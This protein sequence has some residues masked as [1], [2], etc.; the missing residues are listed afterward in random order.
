MRLPS[1]ENI[2]TERSEDRYLANTACAKYLHINDVIEQISLLMHPLTWSHWFT[3]QLHFDWQPAPNPGYLHFLSQFRPVY[4][5]WQAL[6]KY[7][8]RDKIKN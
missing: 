1:I 5:I 3:L 6:N 2:D 8:K 7:F 4:P